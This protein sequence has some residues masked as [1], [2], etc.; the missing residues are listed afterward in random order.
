MT[1]RAMIFPKY[2]NSD[3]V[4]NLSGMLVILLVG[5]LVVYGM[6]DDPIWPIALVLIA[7]QLACFILFLGSTRK[8]VQ[9]TAFWV[10]AA[11][12]LSLYFLVSDNS[13]AILGIVWIV[14]ASELFSVVLS[15]WM[16]VGSISAFT[17]SQFYHLDDSGMRFALIN[18]AMMGLFQ[19]F[20]LSTSQ[21]AISERKLRKE[22]GAL[23]LELVATRELLAQSSAEGERL[24]IARDLHDILGHHMTALILNLE[25]AK[26]CVQDSNN[27]RIKA[28]EK[29]EQSLALAKLLLGDIRTAVSELREGE[30]INLQ[31]SI[32]RMV[33]GIP[34]CK[35]AVDFSDAPEIK[36]L[37]LAE[38]I[39]RCT[40]EAVTN[41]LRHSNASECRIKVSADNGHCVLEVSD[42]GDSNRDIVPGNGLRGME[43]RVT[44]N[45][46]TLSWQHTRQGFNLLAQLVMNPSQ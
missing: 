29:V 41:V 40:Q 17:F 39:L 22:T 12:L 27:D 14:Q 4:L 43:E 9:Y 7:V 3:N 5:A 10:Q 16:L 45:G 25:A 8:P 33:T 24:R 34:R 31:Q 46:G 44:A 21:R 32:N 38:T 15:S 19:L 2:F 42:N 36:S 26:H 18:V 37:Q 1:N 23:N 20:A 28:Q 6:R 30:A 35:I 11:C 13:V